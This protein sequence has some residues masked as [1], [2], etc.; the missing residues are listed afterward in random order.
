[1]LLERLLK[2]AF[3]QLG[4][5]EKQRLEEDLERIIGY[6]RRINSMN[7]EGVETESR[8]VI[9]RLRED[10]RGEVLK[11]EEVLEGAPD[12]FCDMFRTPPIVGG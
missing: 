6:V 2:L 9:L 10:K 1:N 11:R 12:V 5:E 8:N 7:T 3:I 4:E